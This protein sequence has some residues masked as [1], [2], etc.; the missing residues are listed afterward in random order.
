[1][2]GKK[3]WNLPSNFCFSLLVHLLQQVIHGQPK[4]TVNWLP[5]HRITK[6]AVLP[7]YQL[8]ERAMLMVLQSRQITK[9]AIDNKWEQSNVKDGNCHRP[10]MISQ[11]CANWTVGWVLYRSYR[12]LGMGLVAIPVAETLFSNWYWYVIEGAAHIRRYF[13]RRELTERCSVSTV[14]LP[15]MHPW[16]YSKYS[17]IVL[18][19]GRHGSS[20][21]RR[22]S[23]SLRQR[24]SFQCWRRKH[25]S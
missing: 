13:R 6:G 16:Q 24:F 1:M 23:V 8:E 19:A 10:L 18:C 7:K 17:S 22:S 4:L 9:Q 3:F 21:T 25:V 5:A 20:R 12:T 11:L 2:D 15:K 14:I